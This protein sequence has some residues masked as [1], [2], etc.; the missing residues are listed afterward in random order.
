M[1]LITT[2]FSQ[3][4]CL[5]IVSWCGLCDGMCVALIEFLARP[6]TVLL[7]SQMTL[8]RLSKSITSCQTRVKTELL[9]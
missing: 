8:C 3:M 7:F 1:C 4:M 5:F 6:C 9:V 2:R